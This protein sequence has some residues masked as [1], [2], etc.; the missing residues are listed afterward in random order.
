MAL[1]I[2]MDEAGLGPNLGPYVV[3]ATVWQVPGAPADVDLWDVFS[4]VVSSSAMPGDDRLLLGDSKAVFQSGKGLALLERGVLSTCGLIATTELTDERSLRRC[5]SP[6][7]LAEMELEP[8]YRQDYLV[9]PISADAPDV[10]STVALWKTL[11]EK[12]GVRLLMIRSD[13]VEPR[14]FNELI[15]KSSNKAEALSLLSLQLLRQVA[16]SHDG[17]EMLVW[18]DKHGGRNR[19]APFLTE[20]FDGAFVSCQHESADLSSYRLGTMDVRFQPRAESHF[21][22]AV[23]SMISKYLRELAMLRFNRFW[24]ARLPELRP[25]QGYPVDARRFKEEITAVQIELN[26]PDN[27]LWRCR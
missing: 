2:G 20:V 16:S 14:R 19:Y 8:W 10:Q 7:S 12:S 15:S 21:P 18:C 9:L 17:E 4:D 26:I 22:V 25:T 23:A 5:L 11:Q 3:T 1:L 24:R 6:E 27:Q 13:V